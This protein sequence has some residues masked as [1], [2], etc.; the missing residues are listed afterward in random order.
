MN[1][2]LII[3]FLFLILSTNFAQDHS[4]FTTVLQKYVEDGWVNYEELKK[5]S[6]FKNYLEILH[7]T[8]PSKLNADEVKLAFWINAYNAFTLEIILEFYPVE[9]INDLHS[10]GL[11]LGTVLG[12]TVWDKDLFEINGKM[13][14]LN[15]IEHE[16]LRKDFEEPRIHFAIVCA[17][18]G[19]PQLRNEAFE[20]DKIYKQLEEQSIQFVNDKTKNLFD[21]Q[22]REAK[23]SKIFDWFEEDFGENDEQVL[24]YLANFLPKEVAEDIKMNAD[25]WDL[26]YT[27]YDWNLNDIKSK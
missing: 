10:G 6:E 5:D 24:I 3:F 17:S 1:N 8:D 23:I 15:Y 12:T 25:K 4:I 9:S 19:C 11:Y 21:L 2:R 18:I 16:I 27:D 14:S 7:K 26:G 22:N 20:S 13:I